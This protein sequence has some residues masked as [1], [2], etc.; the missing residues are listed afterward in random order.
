MTKDKSTLKSLAGLTALI[1]ASIWIITF[2]NGNGSMMVGLFA[3]SLLWIAVIAVASEQKTGPVKVESDHKN[4]W[5]SFIPHHSAFI[6]DLD[7]PT[8][9]K[10]DASS[11]IHHTSELSSPSAR[12]TSRRGLPWG[13]CR[14]ACSAVR[15]G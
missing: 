10:R 11:C 8:H 1:T 7:H 13:R 12:G 3:T 5:H 15:W 9:P 6:L 2:A 14:K 4:F